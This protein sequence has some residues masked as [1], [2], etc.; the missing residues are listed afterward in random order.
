M[1]M[2]SKTFGQGVGLSLR[3]E[4]ILQNLNRPTGYVTFFIRETAFS[5]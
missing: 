5:L 2:V 3:V 4:W 1:N